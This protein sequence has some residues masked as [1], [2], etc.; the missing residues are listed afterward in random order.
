MSLITTAT[1]AIN[2]QISGKPFYQ[3]RTFWA[4]IIVL[5][6]VGI[7]TKYGFIVSA[8]VQALALSLIN[9]WLRAITKEPIVW[10]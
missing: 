6:G 10:N 3:S 9:L 2:T 1:D 4:N 7:Q 8:E 5:V